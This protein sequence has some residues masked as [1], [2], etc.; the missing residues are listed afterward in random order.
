MRS[1]S[2]FRSGKL[3]YSFVGGDEPD[4]LAVK[5]VLQEK[6]FDDPK[7]VPTEAFRPQA[8]RQGLWEVRR[9]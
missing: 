2:N 4:V 9:A 7:K 5:R 1:P 8:H 3:I 6:G